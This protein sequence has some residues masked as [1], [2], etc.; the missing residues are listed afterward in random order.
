[1]TNWSLI[2]SGSTYGVGDPF[3]SANTVAVPSS[4]TLSFTGFT[5]TAQ[6]AQF[7]LNGS[8]TDNYLVY[9]YDYV[10]A[11][12]PAPLPLAGAGLAFGFSRR[13]RRRIKSSATSA[14]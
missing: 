6:S 11:Q 12:V 14:S 8:G 1:M 10:N 9:T 2:G 13:L 3:W 7:A 5:P 4:I